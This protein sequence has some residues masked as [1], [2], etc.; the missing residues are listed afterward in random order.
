VLTSGLLNIESIIKAF[1]PLSE[2]LPDTP[3]ELHPRY[4]Y[5]QSP[6]L[7]AFGIAETFELMYRLNSKSDSK[8]FGTPT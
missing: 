2:E 6:K 1:A 8:E 3:E 4:N 5:K 7:S